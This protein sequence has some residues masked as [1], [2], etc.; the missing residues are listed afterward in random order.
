M[1]GT[2]NRTV[3]N[4]RTHSSF[5]LMTKNTTLGIFLAV[6]MLCGSVPLGYSEP[7]RVQLEQGIET[8][9]IQCDG[10]NHVLVQRTNGKLAC[11]SE[12]T[13]EKMSWEIVDNDVII[14]V[15]QTTQESK[16]DILNGITEKT[17]LYEN[18]NTVKLSDKQLSITN[19]GKSYDS[20]S[21]EL[22]TYEPFWPQHTLS[23]P[24]EVR[25][26]EPFDVVLDYAF[27]TPTIDDDVNGVEFEVWE[28][29]ESVCPVE[30]CGDRKIWIGRESNVD[31]LNR[32]DYIFDNAG[33]DTR[34]I[35]HR[36]GEAGTVHPLFNNTA[37]QQEIFTLVINEPIIDYNYG[38]I[39]ISYQQ[40]DG[41]I[42][43]Y[44][45]PDGVV[46]LS[47]DPIYM[48]GEG[49]S[50][51]VEYFELNEWDDANHEYMDPSESMM[52][53]FAEVFTEE[54]LNQIQIETAL[55]EEH[56]ITE[57]WIQ[58]FFEVYP[59]LK[60]Q[61]FTPSLHWILPQAY[62]APPSFSAVIG[63]LK[64]TDSDGDNSFLSNVKVC[65][66]DTENGSISPLYNGRTHVCV[67]TGN[68]GAFT[69]NVP[70]RDP[71]G[72]GGTDLILR[73]FAESDDFVV[74]ENN[75]MNVHTVD[76]TEPKN[77]LQERIISYGI[78][79][80]SSTQHSAKAFWV[81]DELEPIKD[82]YTRNVGYTPPKAY[83]FWDPLLCSDVG[84]DR[85]SK[86]MTLEHT[87]KVGS[88]NIPCQHSVIS[89]LSNTDTL[90]HEYAHMQF[91]RQ[92]DLKKSDYP[93]Y[94]LREHDRLVL[95]SPVHAS[96]SGTTWIEGWA[97]F[98]ALAYGL[99]DTSTSNDGIYQPSYMRGQW[100]FETRTNTETRDSKFAGKLFVD[101]AEGEGNVAAALYDALDTRNESGD[102][103]S[104]QLRNIWNT[105]TDDKEVGESIIAAD[106]AEFKNDWDDSSRPSLDSIFTLNTL[107]LPVTS[108]CDQTSGGY[109]FSDNFDCD[110][111]QWVLSGGELNWRVISPEEEI[112]PRTNNDNT[113]ANAA[114]CDT[115]C[116]LTL[117]E[118]VNLSRFNSATLSF[119][120]YIDQ[121]VDG[122]EGLRVEV[123]TDGSTWTE[124]DRWTEIT[125]DARDTW[126]SESISLNGYLSNDVKIRFVAL[127]SSS[128]E[129]I[130][131]DDVTISG[132]RSGGGGITPPTPQ[133]SPVIE[134]VRNVRVAEG[135]STT[136]N[137]RATDA[138][139]DS[140]TLSLQDNPSWVSI[141]DSNDGTGLITV[142]VPDEV[143]QTSYSMK[144]VATDND[145]TDTDTFR[146]YITEVNED[147]TLDSIG[148][149]SIQ[150]RQQL[151]F[152][153]SASDSDRPAQTLRYSIANTP[154]QQPS[155]I[156]NNI[157]FNTSTGLFSW[158]PNNSQKGFH[159]YVF[160]VTDSNGA[161]DS[162]TVSITV[163]AIP[164]SSPRKTVTPTS[165]SVTSTFTTISWSA[166]SAG[167][168]PITGYD[169]FREASPK[170][171]IATVPATQLSY[172]DS[173]VLPSTT[174]QYT[175]SA[176]NQFGSGEESDPIT[177]TTLA[178]TEK[179]VI[180]INP[181]NPQSI[182]K[183]DIY[184]EL[185]A[186]CTDNID[187]NISNVVIV[188]NVNTATPGTYQVTYDCQDVAGNNADQIIRTVHVVIPQV[189]PV[190][191]SI[192]DVI[193]NEGITKSFTV[194]ATDQNNDSITYSLI[195]SPAWVTISGV[196]ITVSAPNELPN[197]SYSGT[198]IATD[199]D[200]TD[201]ESFTIN[202]NEVNESPIIN[203]ISDVESDSGQL[204]SFTVTASDSDIPAQSLSFSITGD[205]DG[206]VMDGTT[207]LFTWTPNNSQVGTH[208]ITFTVTDDG[209]PAKSD[210]QDVTFTITVDP[211]APLSVSITTLDTTVN[212]ES[213]VISGTS[214][215]ADQIGLYREGMF[216]NTMINLDS[217]GDWSFTVTLTEGDNI[218]GVVATNDD[219]AMV[220]T[221][222]ITVTLDT[223]APETPIL[224]NP[225]ET[226][227]I[228]YENPTTFT[229]TAE[230]GST[231]TLYSHR[232]DYYTAPVSDDGTWSVSV[233]ISDI[234]NGFFAY[235][236][237]SAGNES[238]RLPIGII[239]DTN[240]PSIIKLI[241]D[242][243][244]TIDL[245]SGYT[246][247]GASTND[248]FPVIIDDTAFID[249][250]GIYS[251]LYDSVDSLGNHAVQVIRIVHV[252]DTTSPPTQN[253]LLNDSFD[254]SLD[255][256][257]EYSFTGTHSY[258]TPYENYDLSLDSTTGKPAPSAHISGDGFV[259]N[260]GMYKTVDISSID[261][262]SPLYLSFDYRAKSGFSSSSVTNTH[263]GIY[264]GVTGETLH[265]E[266]LI[267]GGTLDSGW[268]SYNTDISGM[269]SGHDSI[270]IRCIPK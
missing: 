262:N 186:S 59:E 122:N 47:E 251:I 13:A 237:D 240:D 91:Y 165:G 234:I 34:Y 145:G 119:W 124:L 148:S 85:V 159:S 110:L 163:T 222:D 104:N 26:G 66:Y 33:I 258:I 181:P 242:N 2:V 231:V 143:S 224:I 45:A 220:S 136:I 221:N 46:H 80:L 261:N 203:N 171:L 99:D 239:F 263:L 212:T 129:E 8:N 170:I 107:P 95:H 144:A 149:K 20:L 207:G 190:L 39:E 5:N 187:G 232:Y 126:V 38:D 83:I 50:Q 130:E 41:I 42:Y 3:N 106:F 166:P 228:V 115:V 24:E 142:N 113:I 188:S 249:A 62:G 157:N 25:V 35:P 123:S 156:Y 109:V 218:L 238:Y 75:N 49:P 68:L 53:L 70:T 71:N 252:V 60:T 193:I 160:T 255:G 253:S 189:P 108:N 120:H 97:F 92:Y 12:G 131:I 192:S 217:S 84:V 101:G 178:D 67:F 89:P 214:S 58:K 196:T 55:R 121:S 266:S 22:G 135:S 31:L 74:Y 79:Q 177:I 241:G 208:T 226:D 225:S 167:S 137:V 48:S 191:S 138:N 182:T 96:P 28:E 158:T 57:S 141:S 245:G 268:Q 10:T 87:L 201:T 204:I 223:I 173:T 9:D 180:V 244:Q 7:L 210:S 229:G 172:V 194:S 23:F 40:E 162:E 51:L 176:K 30:V 168:G 72:S 132:S 134:N 56:Y 175:V 44:V 118:S 88:R 219:G 199:N 161:T 43:F 140:I 61:S 78:F 90:A 18:N 127:A 248:H 202:I 125:H 128:S 264:D 147:P 230:A 93:N 211:L 235:A 111:S 102:D 236:T 139:N 154:P 17:T 174:Y 81:I 183:D 185:G 205:L 150:E 69:L 155:D 146:V 184:S 179:P 98:M 64:Y 152:T 153:V 215:N 200:G 246:E 54:N 11:V 16:M 227:P 105:M 117:K 233:A 27:L 250:V 112:R 133:T 270:T 82:W 114:D 65:A 32:P 151:S 86:S 63:N 197:S 100:N 195:N 19:I 169:I 265:S 21:G 1:N 269:T 254:D 36:S 77:N 213:F 14:S 94:E 37:P 52:S 247:L 15:E 256:W 206:A 73:A 260:S 257:Q 103:Q 243:P 164:N 259:S 76:S 29:P 4:K 198:I 267:T 6:V 116:N 209:T 216:T